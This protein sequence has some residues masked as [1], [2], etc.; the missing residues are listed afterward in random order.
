MPDA[1]HE[2]ALH[3]WLILWKASHAVRE[4]ALR[5]I[6]STGLGLTDFAVL[7]LLLHKG[8]SPVNV[9]GSKVFLTSG[10]VTTAI[11]RLENRNLVA[12]HFGCVGSACPRGSAHRRRVPD[13]SMR[14]RSAWSRDGRGLCPLIGQRTPQPGAVAEETGLHAKQLAERKKGTAL[15]R[16]GRRIHGLNDFQI[17]RKTR[18]SPSPRPPPKPRSYENFL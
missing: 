4:N 12:A 2:S 13:D 14:F 15:Q 6:A 5:Q 3:A 1:D 16:R 10:S 18:P 17:N 9:I 8:P 7:E 11:D